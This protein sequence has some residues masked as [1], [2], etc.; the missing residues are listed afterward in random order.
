MDQFWRRWRW[1]S[2]GLGIKRWLAV[3]VGGLLL[4]GAGVGLVAAR[5]VARQWVQRHLPLPGLGSGW[6][7][8]TLGLL[9]AGAGVQVM[10][11]GVRQLVGSVARALL[12]ERGQ[13]LELLY[14]RRQL[15]RG[16]RIAVVGGGTGLS[17]LLRGLKKHTSNLTAVVT[18][19][20]DG[21][22][23]GRLRTEMGILPPGDIRQCLVALAATE[24]LMERLFQYRFQE[25]EGLAGH[26]FGNLFIAAMTGL[27]GDF[28]AA[29]RESSKVLAIQGQVLP[30]TL[31]DVVLGAEMEDGT[32]VEG[33]SRIA[34]H[35]GRIKRVFLNPP[36][37]QPAEEVLAA[38]QEADLLVLGPGSLF[39]SV[40]PNLLVKGV[41]EA[42]RSSRALKVYVCN[43]MTQP[44]ETDGYTAADHVRVIVEHLGR[45]VLDWAVVHEGP[46]SP[47]LLARYR[48]QGAYP[49][50]P[51]LH[52]IREL[53]VR[54]V[55]YPLLSRSD[56][57]RH[58]PDRLA[59]VLLRLLEAERRRN[60]GFFDLY[61]SA[62]WKRLR[63]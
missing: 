63:S 28:E 38:L 20:D 52:R 15:S 13:A 39:T 18:V 22:S 37:P 19:A 25:G 47:S 40:V 9:A 5:E 36:S 27:T 12:P 59:S 16:P 34:A 23:S 1:L 53:G 26:A 6:A 51:D 50:V 49:V 33:E 42:I 48:Q 46:V 45:G 55:A 35:G 58:D 14:E 10:G 17:T 24:P 4:L 3:F 57:A 7:M 56:L 54:P 62:V 44:G 29:V 8:V 21:G 31:E 43:V 32:V 41:V 11:Y 30:A 61:L 2:P 60:A